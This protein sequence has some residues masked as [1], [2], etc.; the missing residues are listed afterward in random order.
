MNQVR[1]DVGCVWKEQQPRGAKTV[2]FQPRACAVATGAI[3]I[4]SQERKH[5]RHPSEN[6]IPYEK[7]ITQVAG[8]DHP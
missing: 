3:I 1:E 2:E 5:Q 7:T 6:Q 8:D 4:P